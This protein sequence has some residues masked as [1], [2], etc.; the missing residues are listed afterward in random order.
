MQN[1]DDSSAYQTFMLVVGAGRLMVDKWPDLARYLAGPILLALLLGWMLGGLPRD[2]AE[3]AGSH[4]WP[5]LVQTLLTAY[6]VLLSLRVLTGTRGPEVFRVPAEQM[7]NFLLA[8]LLIGLLATLGFFLLIVPGLIVLAATIAWPVLIV[9][10]DQGPMEAVTNSLDYVQG[11]LFDMILAFVA[12]TLTVAVADWLLAT[13]LVDTFLTARQYQVLATGGSFLIGVYLA[14]LAVMVYHR[15]PDL[16]H[17]AAD[18]DDTEDDDT[19]Q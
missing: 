3:A 4:V 6:V 1:D 11:F 8:S 17:G 18:V 19:G 10:E 16:H 12:L 7:I 15:R 14:A 9:E 5:W 13:V 2:P